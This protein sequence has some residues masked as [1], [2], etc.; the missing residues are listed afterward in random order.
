M[1]AIS[2][3]LARWLARSKGRDFLKPPAP[4]SRLFAHFA[5]MDRLAVRKEEADDQD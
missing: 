1:Y 3:T 5:Q 2:Y 4:P